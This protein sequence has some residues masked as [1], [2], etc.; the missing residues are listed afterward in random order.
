MFVGRKEDTLR[1]RG[2]IIEINMKKEG[3][4]DP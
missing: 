1:Q 4:T 2:R 3:G